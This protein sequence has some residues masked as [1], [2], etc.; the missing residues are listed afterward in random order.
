MATAPKYQ[1]AVGFDVADFPADKLPPR[2]SDPIPPGE[3][4]TADDT[5]VYATAL[6]EHADALRK[7]DAAVARLLQDESMWRFVTAASFETEEDAA[8]QFGE[9]Q[10]LHRNNPLVRNVGLYRAPVLTWE[11]VEVPPAAVE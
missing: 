8:A 11:R 6:G 3:D 2:P 7:Y 10:S 1:Y 5:A 4:A 9:F